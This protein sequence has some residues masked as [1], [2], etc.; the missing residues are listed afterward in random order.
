MHWLR[1]PAVHDDGVSQSESLHLRR[2]RNDAASLFAPD[3]ISGAEF[4]AGTP[5][6]GNCTVTR[7]DF[8]TFRT[9]SDGPSHNPSC[10]PGRVLRLRRADARPVAQGEA[11]R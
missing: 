2:G 5:P 8:G 7:V 10:G 4:A 3:A 11:D 1:Q 9:L 6:C